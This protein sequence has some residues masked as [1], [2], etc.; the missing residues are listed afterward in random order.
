MDRT[1]RRAWLGEYV[2]KIRSQGIDLMVYRREM[3]ITVFAL[4]GGVWL[5][6]NIGGEA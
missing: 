5:K 6:V 1:L 2:W 3:Q 4:I